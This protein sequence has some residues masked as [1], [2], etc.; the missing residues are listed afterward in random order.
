MN[1]TLLSDEDVQ[2]IETALH[3][4]E[5]LLMGFGDA[6]LHSAAAKLHAVLQRHSESRDLL[7]N[8]PPDEVDALVQGFAYEVLR[9]HDEAR[10]G[11]KTY[12]HVPSDGPPVTF[13]VEPGK[14]LSELQRRVGGTITSASHVIDGHTAYVDDEGLLTGKP[15]NYIVSHLFRQTIVGDAV[16]V[17]P[18]DA[19]GDT[20]SVTE[21]M[22][23]RLGL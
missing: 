22:R 13:Q 7:D 21:A 1:T 2:D 18:V 11:M 6:D 5:G 8:T 12:I 14:E 19:E 23:G 3:A 20:A 17:G 4:I 16:I 10:E 9:T 15:V